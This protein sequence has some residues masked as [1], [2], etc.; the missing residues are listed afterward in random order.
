MA[1]ITISSQVGAGGAEIAR[2][3]AAALGYG[4]ADKNT[5]EG[6]FRQYGMTKF[7]NL[8]ASSPGVLDLFSYDNL[9]TIAMLNEIIEGL[10][11]RGRMVILGRGGFAVLG[12]Y[13]DVVDVRLEAR[14][15]TRAA[16]IQ[17]RAGLA[18]LAEAE[19]YA[20]AGDA[21]R[22]K[23]VQMFYNRRWDDPAGF[24]LALDTDVLTLDAAVERIVAA[25]QACDLL[26]ATGT[27][28]LEVDPVLADAITRVL[29]YPL[30]ELANSIAS[31]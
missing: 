18:T 28:E 26:N 11:Q 16:R 27:A 1:V 13:A 5:I 7:E 9:M 3:T 24:D 25:A 10:A 22:R 4:F 17:A 6:I 14:L 19:A 20:T 30:S 2:R 21:Q 31:P 29:A 12:N 15:T 23:F 8:Y